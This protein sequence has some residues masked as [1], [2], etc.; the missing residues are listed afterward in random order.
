[1]NKCKC[2]FCYSKPNR[3][4]KGYCRRHY[5]QMRKYGHLLD[6][7][8]SS[9]DNRIEI[10]DGY[11]E[12]TVTDRNDNVQGITKISIEDIEKVKGYHW[13]DN[14]HGYVRT[15]NKNR[16]P[17]YLHRLLTGCPDGL[18]VDHINRDKYD[19]RRDNLRIVTRSLNQQNR[20]YKCVRKITNRYLRKPYLVRIRHFGKL[21]CK[22]FETEIEAMRFVEDIRK[23]SLKICMG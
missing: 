11:A 20:N 1:M 14:G 17:L 18:E 7:R 13:S 9:N 21:I 15:F 10:K 6:D 2:E 8:N 22:Y 23:E 4:G 16:K 19:N 3:S 5:D 12:M